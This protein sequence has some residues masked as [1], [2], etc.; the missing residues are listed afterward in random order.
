[1]RLKSAQ[2]TLVTVRLRLLPDPSVSAAAAT[3]AKTRMNQAVM[4]LWNP[5]VRMILVE[6][7]KCPSMHLVV[8]YDVQWVRA[9]EHFVLAL[10]EHW[11]RD[12]VAGYVLDAR[13]DTT[14][15]TYAHEFGHL[16]GL[17]DEYSYTTA[18][19]QVIYNR[20]D[21]T[22]DPPINATPLVPA[23]SPGATLMSS[24]G[25]HRILSRHSYNIAIEVQD[26]LTARLGRKI[27]CTSV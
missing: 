4:V 8:N 24:Q 9:G 14:A 18:P 11:A 23:N 16:V 10:H 17:P 6:D 13:A 12:Y 7:P 22:Q 5:A 15:E 19:Q 27:R 26:L 3:D 2:E 1:V 20:P 21:G 25:N